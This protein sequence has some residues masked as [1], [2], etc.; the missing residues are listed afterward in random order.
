MIRLLS[1]LSLAGAFLFSIIIFASAQTMSSGQKKYQECKQ[2]VSSEF[3]KKKIKCEADVRES[4]KNEKSRSAKLR[5]EN[6]GKKKC[7]TTLG[8]EESAAKKKCLDFLK[9]PA[10][11]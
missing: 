6:T 3:A 5:C 9:A 8:K 7:S 10:K 11:K 4:C 2:N 1:V